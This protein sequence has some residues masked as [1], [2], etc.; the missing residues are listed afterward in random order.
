MKFR[1]HKDVEYIYCSVCGYKSKVDHRLYT[2]Y[3]IAFKSLDDDLFFMCRYT[4]IDKF[5]LTPI[6]YKP[7][8]KGLYDV[9]L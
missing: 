1:F 2:E 6:I 5:R 8:D 3:S 9:V 4:C 7:I